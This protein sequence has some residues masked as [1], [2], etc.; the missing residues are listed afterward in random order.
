[1]GG[2]LRDLARAS[3]CSPRAPAPRFRIRDPKGMTGFPSENPIQEVVVHSIA[4]HHSLADCRPMNTRISLSTDTHLGNS[5]H[6]I[7][8]FPHPLFLFHPLTPS[9][10]SHPVK[11]VSLSLAVLLPPLGASAL[12]RP[13]PPLDDALLAREKL[14]ARIIAEI[15]RNQDKVPRNEFVRQLLGGGDDYA[16]YQVPCPSD[17]TWIRPANVR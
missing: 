6:G 14:G 3:L 1:M 7:L 12:A 5:I 15:A 2:C 4:I 8:T 17:F 11:M 13:S 16:P 9:P 10:L